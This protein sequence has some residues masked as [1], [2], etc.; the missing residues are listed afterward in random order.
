M[1]R[2]FFLSLV[3]FNLCLGSFSC[4]QDKPATTDAGATVT[5]KDNGVNLTYTD[6]DGKTQSLV[7][8]RILKAILPPRLLG[9]ERMSHTGEKSAAFGFGMSQAEARYG[10][11][12]KILK[13][14]VVDGGSS[15][16]ANLGLA[17]WSQIEL[18]KETADGYERTT[19]IDG[20]KAFEKWNKKTGSGEL[21][22]LYKNRFLITVQGAGIAADDLRKA[23]H[24]LDYKDLP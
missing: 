1:N 19:E 23:L 10:E 4:G 21:L 11:G 3:M 7:D 15:G 9:L 8:F 22:W 2:I 12:A 18:D 24:R 16:I 6:E 20:F 13:V 17:A 5:D 14:Q